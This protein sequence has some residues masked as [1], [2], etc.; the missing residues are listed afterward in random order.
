MS[1]GRYGVIVCTKCGLARAVDLRTKTTECSHCGK[2][3]KIEKMKI[4]YRTDSRSEI[5]WAVGRLNARMDDSELPKREEKDS[6]IYGDIVEEVKKGGDRRERL[7]IIASMLTK[8]YGAFGEEELLELIKRV[9][10][11]ELDELI[12][13]FRSL[14]E[15]YEPQPGKFVIVDL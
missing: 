2:R 4:Y 6:D 7:V 8:E 9:D 1:G 3:L 5:S 15:V 11:G 10:I 14:D 12:E 13:G